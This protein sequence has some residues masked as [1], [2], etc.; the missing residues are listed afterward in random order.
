MAGEGTGPNPEESA[1]K[2]MCL[3]Y[4]PPI[5]R[6]PQELDELYKEYWAYT[7]EVQGAGKMVA[8]E[9][10]E[11]VSTATTVRVRDGGTLTTDGPFAETKETLG[12]FYILDCADLD[13][14]LTWAAK[15][16][17]AKTGTIEV[18]PVASMG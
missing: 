16:P 14:A 13:E 8:G 9:A 1:V 3:I 2:Y 15:I 6:T 5:E 11:A 7:E 4:E 12:G 18:R 10:L 17:S